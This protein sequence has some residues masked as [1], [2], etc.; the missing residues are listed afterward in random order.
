MLITFLNFFLSLTKKNKKNIQPNLINT[1]NTS[2][3]ENKAAT[4]F[5]AASDNQRELRN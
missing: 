5:K 3:Y 2:S 4:A 1:S